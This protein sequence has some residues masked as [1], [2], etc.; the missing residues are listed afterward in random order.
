MKLHKTRTSDR[1][2][3]S[4][5]HFSGLYTST[6]EIGQNEKLVI[7]NIEIFVHYTYIKVFGVFSFEKNKNLLNTYFVQIV[8]LEL[9]KFFWYSIQLSPINLHCYFFKWW[10][11][12]TVI[13]WIW[14]TSYRFSLQT[15]FSPWLSSYKKLFFIFGQIFAWYNRY[16]IIEVLVTHIPS[17]VF[18]CGVK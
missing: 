7:T 12:L 3:V 2:L 18:F 11:L 10:K 1:V 13:C 14:C 17:S 16:L 9:K 4:F 15:Q 5:S 8:M 6:M